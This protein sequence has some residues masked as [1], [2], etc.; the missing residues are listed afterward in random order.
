M[1]T[2]KRTVWILA[3]LAAF[4]VAGCF[5][6]ERTELRLEIPAMQTEADVQKIRQALEGLGGAVVVGEVDLEGH[7]VTVTYDNVRLGKRNVETAVSHVGYAVNDW[8]AAKDR[9]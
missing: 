5:R 1:G 6:N 3:L 4:A 7:A 9:K 8:P 2:M